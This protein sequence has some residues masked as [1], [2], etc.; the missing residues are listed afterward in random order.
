MGLHSKK[1]QRA[2]ATKM[3]EAKVMTGRSNKQL[4][5]DFGVSAG[6]VGKALSLAKQ[7]EIIMGFEDKLLNE[8]LPLA[9]DAITHALQEGNAKVALEIFK[10]TNI[11]R[12]NAPLTATQAQQQDDL[13]AYIATKRHHALLEDHT[14][15]GTIIADPRA[16]PAAATGP[17][18]PTAAGDDPDPRSAAPAAEAGPGGPDLSPA[19]EAR[20]S[21]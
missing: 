12:K 7:G 4:A 9:H 15:D 10:G 16:L 3:L 13:T 21:D 18:A 19:A 2:R 20:I 11:L 8:L 17:A 6:T 5:K 1:L 14:I